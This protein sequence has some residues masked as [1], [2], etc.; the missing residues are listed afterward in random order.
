MS[1]QGVPVLVLSRGT[2]KKGTNQKGQEKTKISVD[3]F[4]PSQ[5]VSLLLNLEEAAVLNQ[6]MG[7]L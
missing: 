5:L 6:I 7:E 4:A 3:H 1:F 2:L